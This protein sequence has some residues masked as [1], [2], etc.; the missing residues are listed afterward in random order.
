MQQTPITVTIVERPAVRIAGLAV[1]TDMV[2]AGQ[3]CPALWHEQFGPRMGELCPSGG[4]ESYG[5]SWLVDMAAGT[6]DYCAALPLKEGLTLP[7][8]M[9]AWDL[10]A[11]LYAACPVPS[12]AELAA[13]YG[14]VY[15]QWLSG[16]KAYA[17]AGQ[18]PCY[19]LYPADFMG[20][21]RLTL[22]VPLLPRQA[23]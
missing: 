20:T 16:Q 6:F 12:L 22:Y 13:A 19:E 14:F 8:G 18:A 3:D 5:A 7:E 11:G 1:R 21:G 2:K 15:S 9:Q 4:C 17:L 23:E 10:P